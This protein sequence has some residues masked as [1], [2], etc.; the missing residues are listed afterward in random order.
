MVHETSYQRNLLAII[1]KKDL[2]EGRGFSLTYYIV[3]F[4]AKYA[5][6][7]ISFFSSHKKYGTNEYKGLASILLTRVWSY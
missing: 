6:Q 5:E 2:V 4:S 3:C 1:H 7:C